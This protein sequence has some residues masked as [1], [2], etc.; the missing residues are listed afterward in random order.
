[1]DDQVV[2]KK[3]LGCVVGAA[4][5]DAVGAPLEFWE[6]ER[7]AQHPQGTQWIDDMLPFVGM[8]TH[9]YGLWRKD[10]PKGTSTD[11]TRMNQVFIETVIKYGLLI[12]SKLLAAEYVDRY[13]NRDQ[14]Y[15]GY[16]ELS[17]QQFAWPLT[18]ACGQLGI[19]CP[20]HPGVPPYV[21]RSRA[22]GLGIPSLAGLLM[23]PS[24]GLLHPGD[25]ETAYK[26]AFELAYEDVGYAKDATA[27][28]AAMVAA[29]FDVSLSPREAIRRGLEVDPF[30]LGDNWLGKRT[31]VDRINQFL[32]FADEAEGDRDLVMIVSRAVQHLHPFDPIDVL[33]LPVAAC[34]RANGDPRRAILMAVNDRDLDEAGKFKRYRDIDC[35]GSVCGALAGALTSGGIDDF[36]AD[37]VAATISA[38]R[39]VHGFDIEA[40]AQRMV[41]VVMTADRSSGIVP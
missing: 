37:W 19:E 17:T 24:A 4:V 39:E 40:N 34:Y 12:N 29:G 15:P 6:S 22:E 11:D 35:T 28:L 2:Q 20:I 5:G 32:D 8:E 26:H 16:H 33:G 7:I 3:F 30:R 1:M 27:L 31:M 13:V 18:G 9:P 36:P 41:E 21:L 23:V 25:P 38:N 10:P 14:Y